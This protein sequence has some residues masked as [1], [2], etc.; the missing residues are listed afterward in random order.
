MFIEHKRSKVLNDS[1]RSQSW[2]LGGKH[3][4]VVVAKCWNRLPG[5]AVEPPPPE[6]LTNRL[7]NICLERFTCNYFMIWPWEWVTWFHECFPA[8]FAER[9]LS[10]FR[11]N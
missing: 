6:V 2:R 4:K 5:E 3:K 1:K 10:P 9:S 8:P 11:L 7:D